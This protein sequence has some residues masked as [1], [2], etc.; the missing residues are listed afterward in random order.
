MEDPQMS[1]LYLTMVERW[2][3]SFFHRVWRRGVMRSG[4]VTGLILAGVVGGLSFAYR[5]QGRGHVRRIKAKIN[6]DRPEASVPRPGGQDA[7]ELTRMRLLGSSMPEFLSVTVLPGRGMNVLQIGAFIPGKGEVNLL[8][9][10]PVEGAASAMT[11]SGADGNGQQ[12][13]SMGGAF[14]VPWSGRIWGVGSQSSGRLNAVWHGYA[15]SLPGTALSGSNGGL[16]LLS[17]A[18]SADTTAFPDGG[19]AQAVY[20]AENFGARWPSKTDVTITVLLG[21]RSIELTVVARNVGEVP[22]PVGIGWHPRFAIFDGNREQLRLHLPCDKREEVRDRKSGQP[23]GALL[24]V[25]GT[26]YDFTARDGAPLGRMDLDDTFTALRRQPIDRGP[27][28]DNDPAAELI[29][30]AN[31]YGLR[32]IASSPDI[33]AFR[34]DAPADADYVSIA[35][36]YNY[37]DPFGREWGADTNTGMVVLQPG[38]STQWKMRLEIF[39]LGGSQSPL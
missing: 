8:A 2:F 32:L 1:G 6:T 28:I 38:Q 23:T 31:D 19:E 11:G 22:E 25:S 17:A 37:D 7:I 39:S 10:P 3:A 21:S 36:Q 35:P 18:D 34:V 13:L 9:S 24:P 20:H 16:M 12:S 27:A 5:E 30:P 26:A 29:D 33:N 14:E 15:I 4:M